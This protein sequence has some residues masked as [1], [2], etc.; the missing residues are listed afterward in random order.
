MQGGQ[1]TLSYPQCFLDHVVIHTGQNIVYLRNVGKPPPVRT[2]S[3][4]QQNSPCRETLCV[5]KQGTPSHE[6]VRSGQTSYECVL[7]VTFKYISKY[8]LERYHMVQQYGEFFIF[9]FFLYPSK[10]EC[11]HTRKKTYLCQQ[12]WKASINPDLFD[13]MKDSQWKETPVKSIWRLCNHKPLP[14]PK[15]MKK[16]H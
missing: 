8:S 14:A 6:R 11:T 1:E 13:N 4:V 16:T 15:R 12:C 9:F 10:P 2:L 3:M 7:W 5:G